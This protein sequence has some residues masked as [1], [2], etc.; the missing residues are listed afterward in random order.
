MSHSQCLNVYETQL[1]FLLL[2][3]LRDVPARQ[4][5]VLVLLHTLSQEVKAQIRKA[6]SSAHIHLALQR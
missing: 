2:P 5:Q 3:E 1:P 4:S 6:P